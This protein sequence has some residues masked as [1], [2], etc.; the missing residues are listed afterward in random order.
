MP[1]ITSNVSFNNVS[2]EW[3]C[4]WSEDNDKKSL[5]D[6]QTLLETHLPALKAMGAKV[7]R[8][9]CGGCHDFKV[10]ICLP[11]EKYGEFEASN[12]GPEAQFLEAMK[13]IEGVSTVETQ[14]FTLEEM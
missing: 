10:I 4:K 5:S 9:V 8:V 2:R 1:N 11:A 7:Q 12:F 14:T 3:R 13:A 6:L